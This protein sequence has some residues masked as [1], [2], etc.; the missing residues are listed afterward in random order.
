MLMLMADL[1]VLTL[2]ALASRFFPPAD[3]RTAHFRILASEIV[4][5]TTANRSTSAHD[6]DTKPP[7]T[8]LKGRD[9]RTIVVEYM[10]TDFLAS[11][12]ITE[13]FTN[14]QHVARICLVLTP[15][16]LRQG[17]KIMVCLSHGGA[18]LKKWR[19]S[20]SREHEANSSVA[21]SAHTRQASSANMD[22]TSAVNA[23]GRSL[24]I[25]DSPRCVSV[26]AVLDSTTLTSP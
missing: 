20:D 26:G 5:T 1:D 10:L 25:S 7:A 14:R 4:K 19:L 23:S 18:A 15:A 21:A 9:T 11:F 2:F 13:A 16:H 17:F 12:D 22:S 24:R 3:A 8:K 6:T